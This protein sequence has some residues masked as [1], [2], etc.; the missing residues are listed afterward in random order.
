[1]NTGRHR[2]FRITFPGRNVAAQLNQ[3]VMYIERV[4][5]TVQTDHI[6]WGFRIVNLYGTDYRESLWRAYLVTS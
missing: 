2:R 5:D 1:L 3:A 4:P 6:D